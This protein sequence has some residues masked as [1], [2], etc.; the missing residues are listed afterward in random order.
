MLFSVVYYLLRKIFF[1]WGSGNETNE[2]PDLVF[3]NSC[4]VQKWWISLL[5]QLNSSKFA[6]SP[7]EAFHVG[8]RYSRKECLFPLQLKW[9]LAPSAFNHRFRLME[10]PLALRC[11]LYH[12]GGV[13]ETI[14]LHGRSAITLRAQERSWGGKDSSQGA[15][16]DLSLCPLNSHLS[17]SGAKFVNWISFL[18]PLP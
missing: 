11:I 10:A 5:F 13:L 18:T 14:K 6:T 8:S 15:L 4:R 12:R 2:W 16:R 7:A 17:A 1:H 3:K 9:F